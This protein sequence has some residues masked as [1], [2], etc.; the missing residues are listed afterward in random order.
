MRRHSVPLSLSCHALV[1]FTLFAVSSSA[2]AYNLLGN[3]WPDSGPVRY[4]LHPEGSDD[5]TDGSDLEAVR[6]SFRAWSCVEGSYFRVIELSVDGPAAVTPDD[7]INSIFWDE[8]GAIGMGPGTLGVTVSNDDGDPANPTPSKVW[9]DIA[10]NGQDHTWSTGGPG[11][12]GV[13]VA[14]VAVHE[15]GHFLGLGHPCTDVAETDCLG[16]DQAVMTPALPDGAV[17]RTLFAD[18]QEG[19]K[20]LYPQSEDDESTCEGP[21]RL[22]EPCAC[23]DECANAALC[24][25]TLSD[26]AICAPTC[27]DDPNACPNGF[28][29]VLGKSG[30]D[31]VGG[32]VA[33]DAEGLRPAAAVC[34]RDSDCQEGVCGAV[35]AVAQFV[36]RSICDTDEHCDDG[37]ACTDGL[38]LATSATEGLVCPAEE[39]PEP[40]AEEDGCSCTT[41]RSTGPSV[42]MALMAM[43]F[44]GRRR[45]RRI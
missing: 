8:T 40:D 27:V 31:V 22:G 10:F 41:S 26:V 39:E 25:P 24:T 16:P 15:I 33:T 36:C 32:C 6:D 34:T 42:A 28:A 29:C 9:A 21:F 13:D 14:S 30:D 4:A 45:S 5:V 3:K 38:C 1:T 11:S 17:I 20:T 37:Y 35:S 44:A 43:V 19:I 7:G 18:D 23:N 12:A 2:H